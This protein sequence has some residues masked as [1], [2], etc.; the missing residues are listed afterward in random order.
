MSHIYHFS[1]VYDINANVRSDG[2]AQV[3]Q[4]ITSSADYEKLRDS[5]RDNATEQGI[6][7]DRVLIVSL[8][9]LGEE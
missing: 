5:L 8:S 1:A 6:E 9:Y 7:C 3:S 4:K 2:I